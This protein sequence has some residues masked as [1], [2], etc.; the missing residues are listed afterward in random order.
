MVFVAFSSQEAW[1][2]ARSWGCRKSMG[3]ITVPMNIHHCQ[4]TLGVKIWVRGLIRSHILYPLLYEMNWEP[5]V[6]SCLWQTLF[7]RASTKRWNSTRPS[8]TASTLRWSWMD[9]DVVVPS[10]SLTFL[11]GISPMKNDY[12]KTMNRSKSKSLK[13]LTS[14]SIVW[15]LAGLQWSWTELTLDLILFRLV[16]GSWINFGV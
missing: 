4:L 3:I 13:L 14:Q 6:A 7:G 1:A 8:S 10:G 12:R 2:C 16:V 5:K 11:A 15:S 9:H